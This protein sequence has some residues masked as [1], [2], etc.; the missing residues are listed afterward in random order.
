M[1]RRVKDHYDGLR[2]M[3]GQILGS[4]WHLTTSGPITGM[5]SDCPP[6]KCPTCGGPGE[7]RIQ[8]GFGEV[9]DFRC[10]DCEG[11]GN[12]VVYDGVMNQR[13]NKLIKLLILFFSVYGFLIT[14]MVILVKNKV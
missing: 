3:G 2:E 10:G 11:S 7:V 12:R 1:T 5:N 13:K 6:D 9:R 8:S 14:L 4:K